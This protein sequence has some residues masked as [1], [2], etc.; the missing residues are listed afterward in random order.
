MHDYSRFIMTCLLSH[1]EEAIK[2]LKEYVALVKNKFEKLVKTIRIDNAGEYLGDEFEN[3]LTINGIEHQLSI[4]YFSSEN[5]VAERENRTLVE[6]AWTMLSD[7]NLP[8]RFWREA[9][10]TT[11]YLTNRLPMK[12]NNNKTPFEF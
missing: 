9:I 2:K 5:D 7:A 12:A 11:T 6:M 3:Y 10:L 1:K 4:P 8:K